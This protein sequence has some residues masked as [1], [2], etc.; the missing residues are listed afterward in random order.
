MNDASLVASTA[1]CW[2]PSPFGLMMLLVLFLPLP[3]VAL[4]TWHP[5]SEGDSG[6]LH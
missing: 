2:F 3:P 1:V 5:W 4:N 6:I